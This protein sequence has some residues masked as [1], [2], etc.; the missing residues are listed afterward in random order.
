MFITGSEMGG[1]LL[2]ASAGSRVICALLAG[3]V[4]GV[5]ASLFTMPSASILLGWDVAVA[6]YLA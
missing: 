5:V 3:S 6:I 1:R 4:S 2:Q